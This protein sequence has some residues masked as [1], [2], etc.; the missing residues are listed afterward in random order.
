MCAG[1]CVCACLCVFLLWRVYVPVL[2]RS[3][4]CVTYG[5]D[6][7][8]KCP[9]GKPT[10]TMDFHKDTPSASGKKCFLCSESNLSPSRYEA[11]VVPIVPFPHGR[12]SLNFDFDSRCMRE[13]FTFQPS[14][15]GK[16]GL[17]FLC[18]F[19]SFLS[20]YQ[21][22]PATSLIQNL[23]LCFRLGMRRKLTCPTSRCHQNMA[24]VDTV[25]HYSSLP[26]RKG[27]DT[28]TTNIHSFHCMSYVHN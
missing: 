18:F 16:G 21:S 3:F 7:R 17:V 1:A 23:Y 28:C 19:F 12:S 10:Y 2:K 27:R 26:R 6:V 20:M 4:L 13:S 22:A 15:S 9:A 5:V 8:A 25:A 11:Y 24:P 14:L